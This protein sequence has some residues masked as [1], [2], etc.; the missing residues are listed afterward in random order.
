M[1]H[2]P[3]SGTEQRRRGEGVGRSNFREC[4]EKQERITK[5]LQKQI[6]LDLTSP[7]RRIKARGSSSPGCQG[8]LTVRGRRQAVEDATGGAVLPEV[9]RVLA[10]HQPLLQERR[11]P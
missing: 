5:N 9:C 10:V 1:E 11:S 3:P 6:P 7:E 4:R 2:T 8:A